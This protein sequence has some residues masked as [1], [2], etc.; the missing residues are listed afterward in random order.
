MLTYDLYLFLRFDFGGPIYTPQLMRRCHIYIYI[1]IY[2]NI[3]I[4]I[5]T[6]LC[7]YF[8]TSGMPVPKEVGIFSLRW[9][10]SSPSQLPALP[11]RV[12]GSSRC[13]SSR[14]ASAAEVRQQQ[15]CVSSN[16]RQ[17]RGQMFDPVRPL[18]SKRG[19]AHMSSVGRRERRTRGLQRGEPGAFREC[20]GECS[21]ECSGEC[22][23]RAC[24]AAVAR[25]L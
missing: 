22:A 11:D 19:I 24:G 1:Y 2:T 3:Y 8:H 18:R 13:V 4:Y 25:S 5:Y 20:N 14:G 21:E 23:A 9:S 16:T 17:E 7:I 12:R 10:K 15:R 6:H